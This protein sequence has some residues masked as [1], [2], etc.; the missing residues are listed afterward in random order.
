MGKIIQIHGENQH[1]VKE[2]VVFY[3]LHQ[4]DPKKMVIWLEGGGVI[5]NSYPDAKTAKDALDSFDKIMHEPSAEDKCMID[6]III[7]LRR[8]EQ[9]YRVDLTR[10]IEWVRNLVKKGV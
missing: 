1:I 8:V 2:K 4:E 6:A 3:A 10:E 7:N 5:T 9:D